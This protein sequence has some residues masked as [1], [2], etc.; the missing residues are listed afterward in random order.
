MLSPFIK[1]EIAHRSKKF[2]TSETNP[3]PSALRR[4][5]TSTC[6]K[7]VSIQQAVSESVFFFDKLKLLKGIYESLQRSTASASKLDGPRAVTQLKYVK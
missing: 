4:L 3:L 6:S 1:A 2:I 7:T 5:W